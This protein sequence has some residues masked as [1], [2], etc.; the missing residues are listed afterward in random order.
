MAC[1]LAWSSTAPGITAWELAQCTNRT[2]G[3]RFLPIA[4]FDASTLGTT[5]P[6]LQKQQSQCWQVTPQGNGGTFPA[7]NVVCR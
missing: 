7:S 6:N 5:I 1:D 2:S 4:S 3:C